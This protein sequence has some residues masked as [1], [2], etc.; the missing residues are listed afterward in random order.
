MKLVLFDIDGTLIDSGGAGTR[1][2]DYAFRDLFAVNDAFRQISM[3]GKT[4]LQIIREGLAAHGINSDNGVV[5]EVIKAYIRH[6]GREIRNANKQLKPGIGEALDALSA[7]GSRI[8]LGLLTG[9]IE[10]GARTKLE[11]FALNHYFPAGA[12]GSDDE[13]RNR[14]LPVAR[15][16]FEL[17]LEREVDYKDCI[18]VGDTPRDVYCAKP[19]GAFCIG[20]ATGPYQSDALVQA[21]ADRVF[22]TLADTGAFLKALK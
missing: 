9:N 10:E 11:A 8:A 19:Y 7:M 1:S 16:R 20:V 18:I 12:F 17:L 4:D 14:L 5:P 15:S 21:G 22:E 2:L 3:A 13:D 6:L